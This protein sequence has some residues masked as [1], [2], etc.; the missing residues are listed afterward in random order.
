M[1]SRNIV[2][3]GMGGEKNASHQKKVQKLRQLIAMR[4]ARKK[5]VEE[6]MTKREGI[7]LQKATG[8]Q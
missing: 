2:I 6:L 7:F 8:S 1:K 3:V 4:M 5:R